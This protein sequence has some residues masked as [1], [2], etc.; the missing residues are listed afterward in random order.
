[1]EAFRINHSLKNIPLPNKKQYQSALLSKTVSFI[2]R[3]RWRL[4]AIKNPLMKAKTSF[5]FNTTNS[6]PP[7]KELKSF[8]DDL[9][10]LTK[11][12]Q[13]RAVRNTFQSQLKDTIKNIMGTEEVIVK[14]D[15][16]NNLYKV[17]VDQYAALV[18]NNI[19]REYKKT[20][21]ETIYKVNKEAK[22]IAEKLDIA[23]R[24][25][26]HT[27]SDAFV[28]I[29]DHKP[30][31]PGK[32]ECRLIN[33]AK[34]NLGRVSKQ[35]LEKATKTI[36]TKTQ[37]NQ[38]TN[39]EEVITWFNDIENKSS[40]SFF[41]FDVVSF[42]PSIT[43][44]LLDSSILWAQEYVTFTKQDIA[45]INHARKSFLFLNSQPW[46][47]NAADEFDVTMGAYDGAEICE[48]VGL[49]IL[50]KLQILFDKKHLGLYRD[51]GL[52]VVSGSGP[53]I[54]RLRKKV[55][56]LFKTIGLQ[57]TIEANIKVTDFLDM[58]LDLRKDSFKPFRKDSKPPVYINNKSNHPPS[59]KKELPKMIA[60][61]I[62]KLS[63]SEEIFNAEAPIYKE[64]LK[65]AGFSEIF[66]YADNNKKKRRRQRGRRVTW[67]N[68]P[69]SET[70]E[71]K[72]AAKFLS[73]IDKHFKGKELG[74]YF[75]RST[76]KV[77][78]SCLPNLDVIIAGH[79]RQILRR[80]EEN[81]RNCN[82]RAGQNGCPI[83][84]NCLRNDIV[85]EAT[86][87]TIN[88]T[89]KY[90]GQASTTFKERFRNHILSF[91]N[92]KY[93][94]NTTLSKHIWN[95][96]DSGI[97]YQIT[98]A[99]KGQAPSYNPST[100]SCKLC[101]LE[102][103]TILNNSDDKDSLNKRGELMSK[104]RHRSKYLLSAVT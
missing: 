79:N 65:S 76:I 98:W 89:A 33:P 35:V 70:V 87:Q 5:G 58:Q 15:K 7:M 101:L 72:V 103:S 92:R 77:S 37:M 34:S 99:Q 36:K 27:T 97:N 21:H 62:S 84:G 40:K 11:N 82:C 17:P 54:E 51:D 45:I 83:G 9:L 85:Y 24:V 14:A 94:T 80:K 46:T 26:M 68:P 12:I 61:R 63:S 19:T 29:K 53:E 30:N 55:F 18:N 8:E 23:D 104:C 86:V 13:Y 25:D 52:A 102:K 16:T 74:K 91:N 60:E 59:I 31:F 32:I 81:K 100:K 95:L 20:G 41:K 73:L 38:W 6:A 28:T 78:Y 3:L 47:K 49:F 1:M 44:N 48:L 42:Y 39:S 56:Q 69:F 88:S 4:Y 90:I 71:T 50:Y 66:P 22:I 93:Q 43:R 67:F 75:N 57:V 64:A 10:D 96:K 2:E